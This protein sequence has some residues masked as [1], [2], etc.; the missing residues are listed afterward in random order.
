[1]S[2]FCLYRLGYHLIYTYLR[3]RMHVRLFVS[4]III[5]RIPTHL[6]ILDRSLICPE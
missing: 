5:T 3:R 1:M 6:H 2:G 4:T